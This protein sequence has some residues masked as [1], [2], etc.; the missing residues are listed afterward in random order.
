M[1]RDSSEIPR[2]I[3]ETSSGESECYYR[4]APALPLL[5]NNASND[6]IVLDKLENFSELKTRVETAER[7]NVY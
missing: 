2:D 1:F 4:V 3:K 6:L 7:M 5:T